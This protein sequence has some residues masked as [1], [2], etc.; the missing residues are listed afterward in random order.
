M[1]NRD[2]KNK[3]YYSYFFIINK[4]SQIFHVKTN[5]VKYTKE[6]ILDKQKHITYNKHKDG[7]YYVKK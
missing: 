4:N 6:K 1:K 5:Y 2:N 3:T 7:K